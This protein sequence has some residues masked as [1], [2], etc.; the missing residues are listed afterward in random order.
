[1]S[2]EHDENPRLRLAAVEHVQR[3][4]AGGVITSDELRMGFVLEGHRFPLINP[5]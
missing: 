4:S 5:Q 3:M 1:M 2:D